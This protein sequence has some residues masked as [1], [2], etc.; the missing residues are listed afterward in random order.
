MLKVGGM[1]HQN[2]MTVSLKDFTESLF[3]PFS[4]LLYMS[5]TMR[6]QQEQISDTVIFNGLRNTVSGSSRS[7]KCQFNW[8]LMPKMRNVRK[9][10]STR[11]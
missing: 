7:E 5:K 4:S 8:S 1:L 9:K 3:I 10:Y 11:H 2:I 6:W